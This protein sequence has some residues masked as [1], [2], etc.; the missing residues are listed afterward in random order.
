MKGG[1]IVGS[2]AGR[3]V[4]IVCAII[5]VILFG[6]AV[7]GLSGEVTELDARVATRGTLLAQAAANAAEPAFERDEPGRFDMVISQ[8]QRSLDVVEASIVDRDGRILCH[9]QPAKVGQVDPIAG[10]GSFGMQ[11]PLRGLMHLFDESADY[12]VIAPVQRGDRLLGFVR[13]HYHSSEVSER[14]V[15]IVG[16]TGGWA[17]LWLLIGGTAATLYVRHITRPLMRLT[18]AAQALTDDRLDAVDL[19]RMER[20]EAG[21]ADEVLTLQRAFRHLVMS[22]RAERAENATLLDQVQTL[23]THLQDR[24]DEVTADLRGAHDHLTAVVGALEEGVLSCTVDGE[25]VQVNDAVARHLE[26]ISR[27]Q[28]GLHIGALVP[29][30]EARLRRTF[31]EVMEHGRAASLEVEAPVAGRTRILAL[32]IVPMRGQRRVP[33]GGVVTVRDETEARMLE[34]Q[35]RRQDRLVSL[36]TLAAGLA[37]ELGNHMHIIQG[38]ANVLVKRLPAE[39][40]F[41]EDALAIHEENRRAVQ[42][43]RRFLQFAR[44]DEGNFVDADLAVLAR[45]AL[46]FCRVELKAAGVTVEDRIGDTPRPIVCDPHLLQQVFI[47]LSLN[48]GDAMREQPERRLVVSLTDAA[49]APGYALG[50]ADS[51]PGVPPELRDRIF[52]PFF[53]TKSTGTGLGLAI[54]SR[55]ITAHRGRLTLSSP[56]GGGAVFTVAL[57]PPETFG[58]TPP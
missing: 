14:A 16:A 2:L 22:L 29:S 8:L 12:R 44:P 26:G 9:S 57:P 46:S 48:A 50:F 7:V 1:S 3:L 36:G 52:D 30:A 5:S 38:F 54:A 49:D 28:H 31:E 33:N 45:E 47:N 43:L 6:Q 37:H 11:A 58:E 27:P 19:T 53:T 18:E 56:P 41:H 13:L 23:N 15:F 4:V 42:L 40:E 35:L 51:G 24:V 32:R 21:A 25:I 34:G 17:M 10:V 39:S 55:I 20:S